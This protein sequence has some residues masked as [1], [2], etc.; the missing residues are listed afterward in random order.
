MN[1]QEC[2]ALM[3]AP[4][5]RRPIEPGEKFG[6]LTVLVRRGPKSY[7]RNGLQWSV[8]K[9]LTTPTRRYRT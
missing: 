1:E 6:K 9:T 2:L 8:E 4:G 5:Q 3:I 7:C